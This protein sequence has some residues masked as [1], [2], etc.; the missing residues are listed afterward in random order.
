[1]TV[2]AVRGMRLGDL[3]PVTEVYL[4][5]GFT[6]STLGIPL[7]MPKP[8]IQWNLGPMSTY[9]V[10]VPEQQALCGQQGAVNYRTFLKTFLGRHFSYKNI[11]GSHTLHK[12]RLYAKFCSFPA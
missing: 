11:P 4:D 10:L 5:I 2:D 1:M 7:V 9:P 8:D 6:Y 3:D 12:S